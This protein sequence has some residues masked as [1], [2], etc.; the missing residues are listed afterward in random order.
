LKLAL[1]DAYRFLSAIS[2]IRDRLVFRLILETGC[3]VQEVCG[4]RK[5]DMKGGRLYKQGYF[6]VGKGEE[7]G[8]VCR[9]YEIAEILFA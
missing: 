4:L 2:S 1:T 5:K 6:Q 8:S 7:D 9:A 3:T